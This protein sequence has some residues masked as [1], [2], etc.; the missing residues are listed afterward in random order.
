MT[1]DEIIRMA[2]EAGLP[3]PPETAQEWANITGGYLECFH[4]LAVAAE[5]EACAVAVETQD[6]C[7]DHVQDWFDFLASKI[8]ARS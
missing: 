1:K 3:K 5:R 7:G 2:V 8:R 4:N 6:T